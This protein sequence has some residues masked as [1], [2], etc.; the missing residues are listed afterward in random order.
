MSAAPAVAP[1]GTAP[2]AETRTQVRRELVREIVRSKAFIAG[3]IIVGFWVICA[4]FGP[5]IE[6]YDPTDDNPFAQ[7]LHPLTGDYYFGTDR[8][9]RDV[10]S[11]VIGGARPIMIV[12]PAATVLGTVC[13]VLL[14]LIMGYYKGRTDDV[15][16]RLIDALI[17]LPVVLVA[18][19]ALVSLGTSYVTVILVIGFLFAPLIARTVR[20]AVLAERDLD[21]VRAAQLRGERGPYVMFVEIL[22]NISGPIIVE[23]TVRLG[24]AIFAMASLS[25][26]GFGSQPP[27]P[28][29]GL[30]IAEERNVISAGIWWPTVFPALAV[31]SLVTGINLI[32]DAVQG[33]FER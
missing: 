33:A 8:L 12:A 2:Q 4:L 23:F 3:A 15:L 18:L 20:A 30:M 31:A 17:S 22:P 24:Y 5:W 28:D 1:G 27:S 11:R 16:G 26:L 9:G 6:T 25:F 10:F 13:G 21:Y 32:A 29:W 19:L 14:G 7:Y